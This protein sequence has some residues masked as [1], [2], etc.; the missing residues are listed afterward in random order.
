MYTPTQKNV[1]VYEPSI[2]YPVKIN[3]VFMRDIYIRT[4]P[5]ETGAAVSC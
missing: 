4:G 5:N 1:I 2:C 3:F